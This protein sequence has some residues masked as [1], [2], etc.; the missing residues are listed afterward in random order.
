MAATAVREVAGREFPVAGTWQVDPAH[1]TVGFVA[2]HMMI[3][4]V[5]G[6][7]EKYDAK[8]EIGETPEQSSVEVSIDVASVTTGIQQ[9]DDHLRSA[10][11][12]DAANFPTITFKG[13]SFKAAKGDLWELAGDLTIRGATHPVKLEVEF[14]GAGQ[15]PW[16][17]A[18]AAFAATATIDRETWG[19][20]YNQALETGGWLVGKEI[21]IEIE[22]EA[23]KA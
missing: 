8:L 20:T 22:V 12:F 16:G 18:R 10:D 11:F 17:G 2:K 4:K 15:D 9:R 19:L 6:R 3:A 7:F 5:R 21:K 13:T 23:S 14:G 1:T